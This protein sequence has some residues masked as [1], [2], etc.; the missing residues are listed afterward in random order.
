M[1][2]LTKKAT[3]VCCQKSK[4]S[5][6]LKWTYGLSGIDNRVAALSKSY[7]TV[8]GIIMQSFKR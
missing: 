6:C 2:K 7:L 4:K 8:I 3:K 1:P 5:A